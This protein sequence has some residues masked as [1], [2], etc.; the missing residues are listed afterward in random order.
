M[1]NKISL[2]PLN[3]VECYTLEQFQGLQNNTGRIITIHVLSDNK[4]NGILLVEKLTGEKFQNDSN[5]L[6][7]KYMIKKIYLFSFMNYKIYDD[8]QNLMKIIKQRSKETYVNSDFKGKK[9]NSIEKKSFAEIVIILDNTKI[10]DQIDLIKKEI[11]NDPILRKRYY[12]SPFFI[13]LSPYNLEKVELIPSKTF[14]Y[15]TTMEDLLNGIKNQND[16]IKQEIQVNEKK[17]NILIKND[18]DDD[19]IGNNSNLLLE[20]D[21]IGNNEVYELLRKVKNIFSYYYEL[22]DMF[23]FINSEGQKVLIN[24]ED[25]TN[26]TLFMNILLLGKSG[27]GKSTL[28]NLLLDEKKSIEGGTGYSATSKDI[29]VYTKNKIPLRFYDLKG[30]ENQ[31]TLD[32][33]IKQIK[34]YSDENRDSIDNLHAIFYCMEYTT[35]TIIFKMED[36]IFNELVNVSIPIFFIITKYK[37][38]P[39]KSYEPEQLDAQKEGRDNFKN[40]I[41][42]KIISIFDEN[43]KKEEAVHFISKFI[44]FHFVNLVEDLEYGIPPFGLDK[45]LSDFTQLVSEDDWEELEESCDEKKEKDCFYFCNKNIFLKHYSNF[46]KIKERN[47][48]EALSYLKRLKAGAFF[49]GWVPGLD[50]GMEYYYRHLFKQKLKHLYGFDEIDNKIKSK[51]NDKNELGPLLPNDDKRQEDLRTENEKILK[52]INVDITNKGRNSISFFGQSI[53]VGGGIATQVGEIAS[54]FAISTTIQIASW[55]I[56]PITV[57]AFGALSC[58]NIHKDCHTILEIYE[59]SFYHRK[60]ETL[61]AYINSFR[62]AIKY[63]EEISEKFKQKTKK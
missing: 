28:I 38:D 40:A 32:N 34:T 35:G 39:N 14:Y 9:N 55:F 49:S 41:I 5:E 2:S 20:E 58:Y 31:E 50:V 52:E 21:E 18:S 33:Y 51:T 1:G 6:L 57:L 3:R 43:G 56:L 59:N 44:R 11:K 15:K 7:E 37:F 30:I 42:N 62:K 36:E 46:E 61:K 54:Q 60:F 25:D 27:V 45:V 63:L 23:S 17:S 48:K 26:I 12:Y 8:P 13:I 16:I 29:I 19:V 22:G 53:H 10:N 24:I 4:K 47:R